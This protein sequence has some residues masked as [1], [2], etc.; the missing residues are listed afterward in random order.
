MSSFTAAVVAF[1]ARA[2]GTCSGTDLGTA[3]PRIKRPVRDRPLLEQVEAHCAAY[4]DVFA[5]GV[6]ALKPYLQPRRD[7]LPLA[8]SSSWW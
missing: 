4:V 3:I 2:G 7:P 6:V 5:D 1:V 8:G